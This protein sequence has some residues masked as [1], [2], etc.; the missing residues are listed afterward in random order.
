MGMLHLMHGS[1]YE[2]FCHQ[3]L[4]GGVSAI[5]ADTNLKQTNKPPKQMLYLCS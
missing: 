5:L 1:V 3:G 4:Q 2:L